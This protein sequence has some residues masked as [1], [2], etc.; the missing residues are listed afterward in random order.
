MSF[1]SNLTVI[2]KIAKS[3]GGFMK[4]KYIWLVVLSGLFFTGC[5]PGLVPNMPPIVPDL[6]FIIILI[7]VIAFGLYLYRKQDEKTKV[8]VSIDKI[9]EKLK[10]LETDIEELKEKKD[11]S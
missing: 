7:F 5:A 11:K 4:S 2:K 6:S 8:S 3:K 10:K 9:L 1:L